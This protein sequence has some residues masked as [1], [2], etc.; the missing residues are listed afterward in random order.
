MEIVRDEMGKCRLRARCLMKM[1]KEEVSEIGLPLG[2]GCW[3]GEWGLVEMVGIG[4]RRRTRR[5]RR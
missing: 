5:R 1:L 4:G 2:F 3:K